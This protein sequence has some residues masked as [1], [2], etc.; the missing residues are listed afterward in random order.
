M[1]SLYAEVD[2]WIETALPTQPE[3]PRTRLDENAKSGEVAA[4]NYPKE[5]WKGAQYR[6]V[7]SIE[8][9]AKAFTEGWGDQKDPDAEPRVAGKGGENGGEVR[10]SDESYE[11]SEAV[12][13]AIGRDLPQLAAPIDSVAVKRR[14]RPPKVQHISEVA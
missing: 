12:L 3:G 14:G 13:A 9:H 11:A 7:F 10:E 8:E 1:G 5:S 4:M 6:V 2:G